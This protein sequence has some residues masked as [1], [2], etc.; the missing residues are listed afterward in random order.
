MKSIKL[1]SCMRIY[2]SHK[3]TRK[4]ILIRT[5]ILGATRPTLV[6]KHRDYYYS[7]TLYHRRKANHHCIPARSCRAVY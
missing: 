1:Y 2:I 5:L 6:P 4:Y 7:I 3:S